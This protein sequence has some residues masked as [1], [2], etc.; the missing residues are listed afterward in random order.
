MHGCPYNRT[1]AQ[2]FL[3]ARPYVQRVP[4]LLSILI[5]VK[6]QS[7]ENYTDSPALLSVC[8]SCTVSVGLVIESAASLYILKGSTGQNHFK[9]FSEYFLLGDQ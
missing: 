6:S 8:F 3:G 9:E 4:I 2:R 7:L 5:P 1:H